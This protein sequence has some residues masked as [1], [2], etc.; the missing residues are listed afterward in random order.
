MYQVLSVHKQLP[1]SS[2]ASTDKPPLI[3]MDETETQNARKTQVANAA[4]KDWN[5]SLGGTTC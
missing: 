1:T 3:L 5:K 2:V 4:K